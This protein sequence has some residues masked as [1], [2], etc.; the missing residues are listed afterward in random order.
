MGPKM[1]KE[2]P[3]DVRGSGVLGACIIIAALIVTIIPR[4][5]PGAG[6]PAVNRF[7]MGGVPGHAYVLDTATG[8]VWED[9]ATPSQGSSHPEFNR[10]KLK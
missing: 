5:Q 9:F 2:N 7:Q 3:M 1:N 6:G 4:P 8:Q 10:P